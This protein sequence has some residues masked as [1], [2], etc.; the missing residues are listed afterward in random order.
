MSEGR[1][2]HLGQWLAKEP[3]RLDAFNNSVP[4]FSLPPSTMA[5]GR[6]KLEKLGIKDVPWFITFHCRDSAYLQKHHPGINWSYHDYRDASIENY[7]LAAKQVVELGGYAFRIGKEVSHP[8]PVGLPKE[9]VDYASLFQSDEMDAYLCSNA[10]FHLGAT[11]GISDLA[12]HFGTPVALANCTP[13]VSFGKSSSSLWTPMLLR[14]KG[15][16]EFLS[17][18]ELEK[19]GGFTV[20][21][22]KFADGR[23]LDEMGLEYVQNTEDEIRD[24]CSDMINQIDGVDVD[25]SIQE[26]QQKF[27]SR[28]YSNFPNIDIAA[29]IAPSF[30]ARHAEL[31]ELT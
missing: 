31:F 18:P 2:T 28:Y 3:Y 30:I 16:T 13:I 14:R 29:K 7:L 23:K 12:E 21:G 4:R 11:T 9:I 27:K 15:E 25:Q 20:T 8:L 19:L 10:K 17:L 5:D 1:A 24:L 6:K 22:S 26:L